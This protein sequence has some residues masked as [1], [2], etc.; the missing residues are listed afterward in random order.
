MDRGGRR[1]GSDR[2]QQGAH[3]DAVHVAAAALRQGRVD[4]SV[5]ERSWRLRRR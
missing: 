2:L 4:V 5:G 1:D 3:R